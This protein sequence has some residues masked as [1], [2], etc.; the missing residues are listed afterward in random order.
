MAAPKQVN[1]G[2]IG[3]GWWPNTMHMPAF[4]ACPEANVVAVC[5]ADEECAQAL[6]QAY[7][8]PHVFTDDRELL[9]S[10]LCEAV[11]VVAH[12]RCVSACGGE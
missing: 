7:N 5:D 11:A 2:M 6:A 10:D 12:D 4:M 9:A 1:I 8:V 3:A